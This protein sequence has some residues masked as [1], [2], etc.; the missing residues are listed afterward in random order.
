MLKDFETSALSDEEKKLF[1]FV[2][3]VNRESL[4]VGPADIEELKQV[5]WP[6]EAIYDAVMVCSLFNFFNR[7]V[8]ATGVHAMTPEE[9]EQD[10][11]RL[12]KFG[13]WQGD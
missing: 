7:W 6:E 2:Q 3:K 12:V 1:A 8:D 10:A 5:G 9:N 13:Y 11:K 4:Q